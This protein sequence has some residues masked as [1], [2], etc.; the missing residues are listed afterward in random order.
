MRGKFRENGSIATLDPP[1]SKAVLWDKYPHKVLAMIQILKTGASHSQPPF[2]DRKKN[3]AKTRKFARLR[4]N[5]GSHFSGLMRSLFFLVIMAALLTVA[6]Y[7]PGLYPS[8]DTMIVLHK[9][10]EFGFGTGEDDYRPIDALCGSLGSC[11]YGGLEP[12]STR[13]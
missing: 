3:S 11:Q 6:A 4:L 1:L 2:V 13:P 12:Q 5:H 9:K 8:D 10:F 7:A